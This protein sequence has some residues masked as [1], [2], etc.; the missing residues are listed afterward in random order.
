MSSRAPRDVVLRRASPLTGTHR[1]PGDKSI[2]HRAA[3]FGAF[4]VGTTHIEGFGLNED[5]LSTLAC[6]EALG[7][8]VDR[9]E[10]SVTIT[11]G[12]RESIV[13]P[14]R[15]IDAGNSGTTMRLLSGLL[16]G[17]PLDVTLVGDASLSA[18]P[19]RRVANPLTSM[20]ATVETTGGHAPLRIQGHSR[21]AAISYQPDPPSAQV[22][23]AVLLA[24]L[25]A[26][27]T[28]RVR[29][30]VQTRDHTERL[31]T[32]FGVETGRDGDVAWVRGPVSLSAVD[33]TVPGDVSSAAFLMALALLVKGSDVTVAG[34]GLNPTRTRLL[35]LLAELGAD[36][37]LTEY[38][39]AA[40]PFGDVRVRYTD[41]LGPADGER[42]VVS[43]DI[44]AEIIDE[45]PILAALATRTTG[46]IRFEGV[47]ELRS[48]ESDRIA[49]MEEG[50]TRLGAVVRSTADTLEV[51]A[52]ANLRGAEVRSHGDHRIA[53]ALGCLGVAIDGE[54]TIEN[55]SAAAVSFPNFFDALPEGAARW[56]VHAGH[57][58]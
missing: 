21:L 53:M 20:G 52:S 47:G 42:F 45:V 16:A 37:E 5:C 29:E 6:I 7:A 33:V 14:D 3:L 39:D 2:S 8:T 12:G 10:D 31:L 51:D 19:M 18:R 26:D 58:R 41:R 48:K 57:E 43:A 35:D 32:A 23:S 38:V 9:N 56:S 49:A 40:E 11:S 46:G 15:P 55:A 27:G 50:L 36:F 54:T 17:C 28:T 25:S 24:G 4:A 30:R 34:V 13:A 1:V 44:V 22:K